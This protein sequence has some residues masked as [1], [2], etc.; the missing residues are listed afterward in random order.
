[1]SASTIVQPRVA[2][3]LL[4][5]GAPTD[6]EVVEDAHM[7]AL[8]DQTIDEVASDEACAPSYQIDQNILAD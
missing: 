2:L 4:K 7:A 3:V 5:I 8:V 6:D 1:M